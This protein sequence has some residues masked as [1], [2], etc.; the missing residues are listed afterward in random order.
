MSI[1]HYDKYIINPVLVY[2]FRG[3]FTG[4]LGRSQNSELMRLDAP[5]RLTLDS[6]DMIQS[7]TEQA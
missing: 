3:W 5:V 7:V 4:L 6:L 1:D 2:T